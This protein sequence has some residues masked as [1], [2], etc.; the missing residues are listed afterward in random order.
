M[1]DALVQ[2]AEDSAVDSAQKG[3]QSKFDSLLEGVHE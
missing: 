1:Q 2:K 3:M